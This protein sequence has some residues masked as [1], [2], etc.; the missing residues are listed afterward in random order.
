MRTIKGPCQ[1]FSKKGL[2]YLRSQCQLFIADFCRKHLPNLS[3]W[4]Y[5]CHTH[6]W[7]R[8]DFTY[9]TKTFSLSCLCSLWGVF[10]RTRPILSAAFASLMKLL[11]M[12]FGIPVTYGTLKWV[13]YVTKKF[14]R[15]PT[16]LLSCILFRSDLP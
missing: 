13:K 3:A 10:G 16:K 12:L 14:Q 8:M 1:Q 9:G 2:N 4:L 15:P 11:L 7:E 5:A 6:D